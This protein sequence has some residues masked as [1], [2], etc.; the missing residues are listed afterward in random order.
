MYWNSGFAVEMKDENGRVIV[1]ARDS[2]MPRL[3]LGPTNSWN[4]R[5]SKLRAWNGAYLRFKNIILGYTIPKELTS[6]LKIESV[7]LYFNGS[8][9]FTIHNVPGGYDPEQNNVYNV[10]PYSKNYIF[11]IQVKL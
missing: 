4:W 1:E 7:R 3:T 9:L 6:K 8:D 5:H 2:D 11:G 10:Y